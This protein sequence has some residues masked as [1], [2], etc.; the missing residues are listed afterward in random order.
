MSLIYLYL[1]FSNM[2]ETIAGVLDDDLGLVVLLRSLGINWSGSIVLIFLAKNGESSSRDIEQG[3]GLRHSSVSRV[4]KILREN[5]WVTEKK[6]K[7]K[8]KGTHTI[9][10]YT[11]SVSIADIATHFEKNSIKK[12]GGIWLSLP[13]KRVYLGGLRDIDCTCFHSLPWI[14]YNRFSKRV[15]GCAIYCYGD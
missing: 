1:T 2:K 10:K 5:N 6:I 8:G 3:V 4:I 15:Y 12:R 7:R 11:L 14:H 13:G 9:T